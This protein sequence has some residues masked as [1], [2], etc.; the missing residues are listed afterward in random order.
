M[1]KKKAAIDLTWVRHKKVGGTE[2][3]I[4]NL[5]DGLS[6]INSNEFEFFLLVTKDNAESF[7]K[8][9]QYACFRF[10]ICNVVSESQG[11]RVIWQNMK[12]GHMLKKLDVKI[13]LEPVYGKPFFN[14]K[15]IK[16]V[17]TIHDLQ[18]LH[19]PQ[20]FTMGRVAWMKISWKNAVY[21]S[22]RII[23]ISHYVKK[24][25]VNSYKIANDKIQVIYDAV[26]IDENS[27]SPDS[28]LEKFGVKKSEYYYTVSSLFLHKNL[29][30]I[31]LAVSEL[32]RRDSHAF[33]PLVVS[34]I[35]GRKRDEL[36]QIIR[37]H[38]LEKDIIFTSFIE[39]SE[40]NMLYRN[41]KAYV[42]PSLFEGFGMPP[43][44]AMVFEVPVLTTK[45]SS[46][47]EVTGGLCNYVDN[48]L[49][50][51]EW[52]DKL[53]GELKLPDREEVC[54]LMKKYQNKNIAEQ[55]IE[56]FREL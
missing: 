35:G 1:D 36:D 56:L 47:L 33:K 40:R 44:E 41:C 48:P 28:E 37:E 30:T 4:R 50:P 19:Y 55:Y 49:D 9:R 54:A 22:D 16:F 52:A 13:C 11:R 29:K 38:S 23:A 15:G 45:C 32:K 7:K 53:E 31:I 5:L 25:I 20:Y 18:A 34:G 10:I 51:A 42:F 26:A 39:D 2:S 12:L 14:V 21:S 27:Y 24:D 3:C 6:E 17:T 8:Y 46:L 43:L